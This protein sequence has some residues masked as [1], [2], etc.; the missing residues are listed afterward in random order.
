VHILF[1]LLSLIVLRRAG[2]TYPFLRLE[3]GAIL[4]TFV[5]SLAVFMFRLEK[6]SSLLNTILGYVILIPGIFILRSTFGNYLFR[7]TWLI[8]ILMVFIGIIY[9]V[10]VYVVSKKYQKE[11]KEM[12]DLLEKQKHDA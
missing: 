3:I 9:G 4:V 5:I 7:F 1:I 6:G 10:A 11:A 2:I 12:N 8:Y